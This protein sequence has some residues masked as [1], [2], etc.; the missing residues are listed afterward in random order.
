MSS[1][2][3]AQKNAGDAE[4]GQL[5]WRRGGAWVGLIGVGLALGLVS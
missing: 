1:S 5:D 2:G 4:Q 3:A